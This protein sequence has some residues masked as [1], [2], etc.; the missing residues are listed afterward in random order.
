[1]RTDQELALMEIATVDMLWNGEND[2]PTGSYALVTVNDDIRSV[3]CEDSD[4]NAWLQSTEGT[5]FYVIQWDSNGITWIT[6]H[7]SKDDATQ[8]VSE[9]ETEYYAWDYADIDSI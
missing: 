5:T 6:E 1:M 9:L 7:D 8:H 2:A 3:A 4:A